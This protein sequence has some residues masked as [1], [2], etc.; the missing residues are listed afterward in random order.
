MCLKN[1]IQHLFKKSA[2]VNCSMK[3][4]C[5]ERN[6]IIAEARL[7]SEMLDTLNANIDFLVVLV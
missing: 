6:G 1:T 7:I 3:K 5:V 2:C 4:N